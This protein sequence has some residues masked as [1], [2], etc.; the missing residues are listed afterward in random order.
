M[1]D[2]L[3]ITYD[4]SFELLVAAMVRSASPPCTFETGPDEPVALYDAVAE[5]LMTC[6]LG[7]RIE[8]VCRAIHEQLRPRFAKTV[9]EF[10]A[11]RQKALAEE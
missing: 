10:E 6:G 9:A 11:M 4:R 1:A 3:E 7:D 8:D 2:E 5:A